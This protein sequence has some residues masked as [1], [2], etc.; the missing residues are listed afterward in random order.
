MEQS[1]RGRG[2]GA[3][4]SD[5]AGQA[6]AEIGLVSRDLADLIQSISTSTQESGGFGHPGGG[7]DAGYFARN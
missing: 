4:L 1:T 3:K 6:L 2:R 7:H 5:A